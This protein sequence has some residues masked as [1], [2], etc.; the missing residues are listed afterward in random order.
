MVWVRINYT[1]D[2][3]FLEVSIKVERTIVKYLL[4]TADLGKNK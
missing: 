4:V 3:I 2:C 1:D